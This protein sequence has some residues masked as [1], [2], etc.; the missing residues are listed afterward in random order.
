MVEILKLFKF[1]PVFS[2]ISANRDFTYNYTTL[3]IWINTYPKV[4]NSYIPP[5]PHLIVGNI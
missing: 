1:T 2:P 3:L 4:Q 5:I